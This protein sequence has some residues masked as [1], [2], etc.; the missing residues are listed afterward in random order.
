MTMFPFLKNQ[1]TYRQK[2]IQEAVYKQLISDWSEATVLPKD[3][4]EILAKEWPLQ[5]AVE[6]FGSGRS[7][8]AVI[9][10]SDG[11]VIEAVLIKNAD[12][13]HTVCVS[14]QAGCPLNCAF[15]ATGKN[16]FKRDL[17]AQEIVDQVLIFAREL[18]ASGARVDN[19]VFMGM[20]EPF[21]NW[22]AVKSA[23]EIINGEDGLNIGAR[24]ISISTCGL[25]EGI[26][27][28]SKFPLQVNLALSLHAPTD[29]LR[30]E[31]MPI[32]N[33]YG[34]DEIWNELKKYLAI[35]GRKVMLEYMMIDGINDSV[36]LADELT[37]L[38]RALPKGLAMV[39][40]IPY[41]PTGDFQ[42]SDKKQVE[43]F[44]QRLQRNGIEAVV[45]ESVGG[46]IAGACGQLAG[47]KK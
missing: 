47:K 11:E 8:K 10:L 12:G 24:S 5:P 21:L 17:T 20:G 3:L 43:L 9:T 30:R 15:C 38:V 39:N 45:R 13:R 42:P 29:E 19:V 1:P 25:P 36:E 33:S 18:K 23:I 32:A 40:L 41:N 4:R 35:K 28:L 2:Q 22:P 7:R 31:L 14:C 6:F 34:L 26:R 37:G 46:Q 16:G 44:R 27:E